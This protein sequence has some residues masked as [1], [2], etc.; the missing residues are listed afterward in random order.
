MWGRGAPCAGVLVAA[1]SVP[2]S[3]ASWD[4][5]MFT[6]CYLYPFILAAEHGRKAAWL[7][8][9]PGSLC[10]LSWEGE[11]GPVPGEDGWAFQF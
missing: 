10:P 6:S 2:D 3:V 11:G 5:G 1:L 4:A 7:R 9:S 8:G